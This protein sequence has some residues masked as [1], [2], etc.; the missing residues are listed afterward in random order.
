M[1]NLCKFGHCVRAA[2]E[3]DGWV[4]DKDGELVR[5]DEKK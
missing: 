2:L 3:Q 1:V 4:K 5:K